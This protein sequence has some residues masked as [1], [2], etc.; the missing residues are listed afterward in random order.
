MIGTGVV[1]QFM[2]FSHF[3]FLLFSYTSSKYIYVCL[4]SWKNIFQIW[5]V[6]SVISHWYYQILHLYSKKN[7]RINTVRGRTGTPQEMPS[8]KYYSVVLKRHHASFS[9]LNKG[10]AMFLSC[11]LKSTSNGGTFGTSEVIHCL[12]Q[13]LSWIRSVF[14][15]NGFFKAGIP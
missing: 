13:G 2:L 12:M 6:F 14:M 15:F 9:E 3:R 10:A 5:I 7:G 1:K 8:Y 11:D 4:S